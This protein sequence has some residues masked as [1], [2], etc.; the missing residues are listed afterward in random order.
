MRIGVVREVKRSERRVALT[1]AGTRMLIQ[2]SELLL[3]VK[4]PTS[5]EYVVASRPGAASDPA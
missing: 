3:K 5:D 2:R 4:E 1:P